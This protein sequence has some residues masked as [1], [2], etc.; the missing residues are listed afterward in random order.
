MPQLQARPAQPHDYSRLG[1]DL[2]RDLPIV[3]AFTYVDLTVANALDHMPSTVVGECARQFYAGHIAPIDDPDPL[4]MAPSDLG[5]VAADVSATCLD[6]GFMGQLDAE[7]QSLGLQA[8]VI[9]EVPVR[10]S[11]TD[12]VVVDD[13]R[14]LHFSSQDPTTLRTMAP[15]I[16]AVV[17]G[18]L[19]PTSR[20][21]RR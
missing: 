18:D 14:L 3:P 13:E 17:T 2:Y 7:L 12:L 8:D 11:A 1:G 4:V 19:P 9:G 20:T 15:F 6:G 10:R 21:T 16:N 5:L